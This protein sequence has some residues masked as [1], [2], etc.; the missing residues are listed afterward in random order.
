MDCGCC[1]KTTDYYK[2]LMAV[3]DLG[4]LD[5]P[6]HRFHYYCPNFQEIYTI[7]KDGLFSSIFKVTNMTGEMPS[8]PRSHHIIRWTGSDYV[9]EPIEDYYEWKRM[10]VAYRRAP[11]GKIFCS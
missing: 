6:I 5:A 4:H 2:A 9:E 11:K 10:Q 1:Y 7:W 8:N 3:I